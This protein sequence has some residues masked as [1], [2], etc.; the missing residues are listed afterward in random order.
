MIEL[1]IPKGYTGADAIAINASGQVA[2]VLY[3]PNGRAAAVWR[4]VSAKPRWTSW[5]HRARRSRSASPITAWWSARPATTPTAGMPRGR[6]AG[7]PTRPGPTAAVRSGCGASGRTARVRDPRLDRPAGGPAARQR[8]PPHRRQPFGLWMVWDLPQRPGHR[9]RGR[10]GPGG[11]LPGEMVVNHLTGPYRYAPRPVRPAICP[12]ARC[13]RELCVRAER[14]GHDGRGH[15]G[16]K[17]VRWQC[18]R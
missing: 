17:P 9:G 7:S 11:Q 12:P 4:S 1:P 10:R 2:G 8:A 5:T 6:A 14:H 3:A 18:P 16:G 15:S 13:D